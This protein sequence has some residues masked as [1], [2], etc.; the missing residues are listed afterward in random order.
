MVTGER[1]IASG[2]LLCGQLF[3]GSDEV[4]SFSYFDL[5]QVCLNISKSVSKTSNTFKPL[6]IISVS[7]IGRTHEDSEASS[8][9]NFETHNL[10]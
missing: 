5:N 3:E 6:L 2:E 9:Q 10:G 4:E 8:V 1:V 7:L